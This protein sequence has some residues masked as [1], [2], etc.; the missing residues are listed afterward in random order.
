[1]GNR[2]KIIFAIIAGW[3]LLFSGILIASDLTFSHTFSQLE[4]NI[5]KKNTDRIFRGLLYN[6]NALYT[7][8][9]DN[10]QWVETSKYVRGTNP[11]FEKLLDPHEMFP[12]FS[13]HFLIL[14]NNK[15]HQW[16]RGYD[17]S[18]NKEHQVP[19]SVIQYFLNKAPEILRNKYRY[20]NLQSQSKFGVIGFY[21]Y[22]RSS[23]QL[24]KEPQLAYIAMNFIQTHNKLPDSGRNQD[25]FLIVGKLIKPSFLKRFSSETNVNVSKL[26]L[27]S[28]FNKDHD[29]SLEKKLLQSTYYIDTT[30]QAHAV[31]YRLIRDIENR[32]VAVMK[33][34]LSREVYNK[35]ANSNR[36]YEIMLL[37]IAV[38]GIISMSY[39]IYYFFR[40][41]ELYTNSVQRFVPQQLIEILNKKSIMDIHI[42][43][44][45]AKNISVLFL[46]IRDSTSIAEKMDHQ[47]NFHF[48]NQFMLQL[49]PIIG[50]HNGFIDKFIGDCIMAIFPSDQSADDAINCGLQILDQLSHANK[51]KVFS[52]TEELKVGVGINT[53]D[54]SLGII[55]FSDRLEGTVIGDTVNLSARIE[56]M[57]KTYHKDLLISESTANSIIHVDHYDINYVDEVK[58]K[59]KDTATKLFTVSHRDM[60]TEKQDV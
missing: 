48:I 28:K 36:F 3:A 25:G 15:K 51:Q 52:I 43:D 42:G 54:L 60:I 17:N 11:D 45:V 2:N 56:S 9:L 14:Y 22:P 16:Q 4:K 59:G 21:K 23:D 44:R 50:R 24:P 7:W 12:K 19:P 35:A 58:V 47:Q 26:E 41:Q 57:T 39:I 13:F 6:L 49:A 8:S 53:G 37:I 5:A 38:I 1:M 32:P 31:A 30:N 46:D 40:K 55:G 20:N 10:A 18:T 27:L 33:V 34:N 29:Q